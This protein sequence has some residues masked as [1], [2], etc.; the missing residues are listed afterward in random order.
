[1][2]ALQKRCLK[3]ERRNKKIKESIFIVILKELHNIKFIKLSFIGF[4]MDYESDARKFL[5]IILYG[6]GVVA[7][8]GGIAWLGGTDPLKRMPRDRKIEEGYAKPSG[9]EIKLKDLNGDG[10]NETLL[11]Y[12]GKS[13]LLKVDKDG[14][15][16]IQPYEIVPPQVVPKK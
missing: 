3:K 4:I 15:P 2:D 1:M 12:E 7:V 10:K 13:Y 9:L 5:G 11:N 16:V 14:T 6:L 8:S